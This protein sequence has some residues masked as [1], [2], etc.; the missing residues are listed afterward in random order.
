M[1]ERQRMSVSPVLEAEAA[2]LLRKRLRVLAVDDS[3]NDLHVLTRALSRVKGWNVD[4]ETCSTPN[5][6]IAAVES[7]PNDLLF[8]DHRLGA[9]TGL[10]LLKTIRASGSTVP[11]IFLTGLGD[12]RV[13]VEVMQAG[14]C[15]CPPQEDLS[16]AP[17]ERALAAAIDR[18]PPEIAADQRL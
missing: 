9:V 6:F 15:D 13:A 12:E 11:A 2:R 17:L 18:H 1:S 5:E 4:L 3:Q 16:T 14:A 8:I 7:R 10:E